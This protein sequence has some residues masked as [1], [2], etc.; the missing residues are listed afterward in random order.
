VAVD[1]GGVISV[2][3]TGCSFVFSIGAEGKMTTVL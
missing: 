1:A 3:A 2:A